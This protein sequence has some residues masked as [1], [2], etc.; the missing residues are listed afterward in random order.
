MRRFMR[1]Y[2]ETVAWMYA[3][4]A[5]LKHYA[6]YSGLPDTIVRQVRDFIPKETMAPGQIVGFDQ[7]MAD[8]V[9]LKFIPAPLTRRPGQRTGANPS[10]AIAAVAPCNCADAQSAQDLRT[11]VDRSRVARGLSSCTSC[12]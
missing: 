6:E 12:I 3:D 10:R 1:A 11:A 4:P 9:R 2:L 8:A 7:A 5:A